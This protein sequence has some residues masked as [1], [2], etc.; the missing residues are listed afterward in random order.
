VRIGFCGAHRT[1]KTTLAKMLADDFGLRHIESSAGRIA[2]THGLSFDKQARFADRLEYQ[3]AV[4]ENMEEDMFEASVNYVT[5]RTPLD[6]AAYLIADMQATTGT[7][8]EHEEA[9][10]YLNQALCLTR[11]YFDMLILVPPALPYD[12]IPGKPPANVAYQEHHHLL[13]LGQLA[14][15]EFQFKWTQV[16]RTMLD[17]G[18]RYDFVKAEMFR[19]LGITRESAFPVDKA[20]AA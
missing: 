16:P 20:Q 13:V 9:L 3:D 6:A 12:D 14:D 8:I 19:T 17:L 15:D 4:L 11:D 18:A 7:W 2:H 5:D 10:I 1:G